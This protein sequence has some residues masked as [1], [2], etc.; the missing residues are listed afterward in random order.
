MMACFNKCLTGPSMPS[1]CWLPLIVCCFCF[2]KHHTSRLNCVIDCIITILIDGPKCDH[3]CLPLITIPSHL[4]HHIVN[5]RRFTNVFKS[6]L[7]HH[8]SYIVYITTMSFHAI[9]VHIMSTPIA[10]LSSHSM[11][12]FSTSSQACTQQQQQEQRCGNIVLIVLLLVYRL[13]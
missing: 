5:C 13:N 8:F 2:Y 9:F 11:H 10:A 7:L 12:S 3:T 1:N 4:F 6:Q